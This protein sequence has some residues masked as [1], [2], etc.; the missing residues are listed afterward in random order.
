MEDAGTSRA[1]DAHSPDLPAETQPAL[2]PIA[3]PEEP[4]ASE[5]S[6]QQYQT[7]VGPRAS[8]SVPQR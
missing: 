2:A 6:S 8:S 3:V 4:Q 1:V 5:P 7:R